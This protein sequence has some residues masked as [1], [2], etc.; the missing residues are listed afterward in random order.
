[1]PVITIEGPKLNKEQKTQL[2]KSFSESAAEIMELPVEAM[3][4][5]NRETEPENVGVGNCLLC[6][7]KR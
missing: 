5:K 4:I 3:E 6:D 2:V 7:I 1:M